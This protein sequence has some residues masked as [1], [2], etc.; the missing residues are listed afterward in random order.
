MFNLN[1]AKS[2]ISAVR[3]FGFFNLSYAVWLRLYRET[4]LFRK[5]FPTPAWDQIKLSSITG[6][7]T[8][9][10][11]IK[12]LAGSSVFFPLQKASECS[13]RLAG[14]TSVPEIIKQA[15]E[16][17]NNNFKYFSYHSVKCDYPVNW[18]L[19]PFNGAS[20]PNNVHWTR[21]SNFT[22]DLGDVKNVWELSRFSWSYCLARAY[23]VSG[24]S[25]Y[26][27]KFWQ[28]FESW[29]DA[30]QPNLGINW[31]CGQEC[32]IRI[33]ALCFAFFA[34]KDAGETTDVRIRQMLIALW[35][36]GDRIE[37]HIAD[38]I[39]Q[40][41]N[42]ALTEAAGLYTIGILF[43]FFKESRRWK[44]LGGKIL[45]TQGLRQIYEDGSYIQ[46]SMNYHRLMLQV[47]IWSLGL[48]VLNGD[49]FKQE[50]VDRLTSAV[51]FLY[52]MHDAATGRVPNYGAN[53]GAVILPL[54][55]C[56][57]LDYRP[58]IQSCWYLL[59]RKR[60]FPSGPWDEDIFWFFGPDALNA[61]IENKVLKSSAFGTGGYYTLRSDNSFALIRCHSYRDRMVHVDP[62][63][64]DLWADGVNILRD[65]GSYRYYLPQERNLEEYFKS[66]FAHNTVIIN[67]QSP[68]EWVSKFICVPWLKAKM[69][70]FD[71]S[72]TNQKFTGVNEAYSRS[73]WKMTHRRTVNMINHKW[74]IS[75]SIEG[76]G[77]YRIE[78]RWHLPQGASIRNSTPQS[79]Y[80][81]IAAGWRLEIS[82]QPQ[83]NT[84]CCAKILSSEENAGWE[85]LY[86]GDRKPISTLS[87]ILNCEL[88]L[89]IQTVI[90][91]ND[92]RKEL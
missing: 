47:Y 16:I 25:K 32:A 71:I 81:N 22:A 27:K 4:P 63:H 36:H 42:H 68:V 23:L 29:L 92:S 77:K 12:S 21:L 7:E 66:I 44:K 35:V 80:L 8:D 3:Y 88:P 86:Y 1:Q 38:A 69:E 15:D 37:K 83:K 73:P 64:I 48:A 75:D 24:D 33:M 62:L 9:F 60:I 20:W 55:N 6:K 26:A 74:I 76:K 50:L 45:H 79:I 58:V 54:N 82:S 46:Q 11:D 78:L 17:V 5:K 49:T 90:S 51:E 2:V 84:C 57:Y 41:T 67:N 72:E 65:C 30:N 13:E 43:P 28:L 10:S 89:T 40:K 31:G 59:K 53:D 70:L 39:R 18:R 14:I 61:N 34:F 91:K 52:Q 19:N 87:F 85:S 56:D